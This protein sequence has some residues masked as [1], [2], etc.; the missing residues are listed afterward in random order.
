[1]RPWHEALA[2][3]RDFVELGGPVL[4]PILAV[5]CL[6]WMLILERYWYFYLIHPRIVRD[7]LAR[8]QARRDQTSWYAH[9]IRLL[10]IAR[11]KKGLIRSL[12][13]VKTCVSICLLLGLLGTIVGMIEVF[14]V[15][16]IL[17]SGNPRAMAS[18][19]YKAMIPTMS[20]MVAAL[21]GYYF[22]ARMDR[23]ARA[24]TELLG[25]HLTHR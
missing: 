13:I 17:G 19:V 5:T 6:M 4:Y 21:S 12:T 16:A 23:F 18:G 3:A 24:E 2:A 14:D 11:V 10:L 1:M 22:S 7:T 20:G 8:W 25:E 9:Q 15:M